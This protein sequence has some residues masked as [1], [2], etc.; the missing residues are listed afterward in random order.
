MA[1]AWDAAPGFQPSLATFEPCD[2][3]KQVERK[4]LS[5]SLDKLYFVMLFLTSLTQQVARVHV[6]LGV[7]K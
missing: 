5:A 3:I 4:V 6:C 1:N 7:I 2:K